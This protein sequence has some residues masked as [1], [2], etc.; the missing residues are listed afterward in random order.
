VKENSPY[1]HKFFVRKEYRNRSCGKKM[2]LFFEKNITEKGYS[3]IELT[4]REDN[5][6]AIQFYLKN[7]FDISGKRTDLK[8]KSHLLIMTKKIGFPEV[9]S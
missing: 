5:A 3:F 6:R 4:V 1:I 2:L 9:R 8:D 7:K